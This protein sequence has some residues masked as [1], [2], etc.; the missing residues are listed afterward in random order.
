MFCEGLVLF[1][2]LM[3]LGAAEEGTLS[4]RFGRREEEGT[5]EEGGEG[6]GRVVDAREEVWLGPAKGGT[7]RRDVRREDLESVH[8]QVAARCQILDLDL[9]LL[10]KDGGRTCRL[11][12]RSGRLRSRSSNLPRAQ[13]AQGRHEDRLVRTG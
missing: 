5:A 6:R 3:I 9:R 12:G 8:V 11:R 2:I 13:R 1:V 4:S 10:A 7:L